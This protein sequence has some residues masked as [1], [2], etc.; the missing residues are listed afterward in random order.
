M[1]KWVHSP[2][3]RWWQQNVRCP[4]S[5]II[6]SSWFRIP[7][8]PV[9]IPSP[10]LPSRIRLVPPTTVC[11]TGSDETWLRFNVHPMQALWDMIATIPVRNQAFQ[12]MQV[13]VVAWKAVQIHC[14]APKILH[15]S[16]PGVNNP[17]WI[18]KRR[19]KPWSRGCLT[20]E[21][22]ARIL[23]RIAWCC[24]AHAFDWSLSWEI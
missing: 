13:T 14:S 18:F 10:H 20:Y 17:C 16:F 11:I 5:Q 22:W 23:S 7:K 21:L 3:P 2:G 24:T 12:M 1:R 19:R 15:I 8:A 9:E 6:I 4:I